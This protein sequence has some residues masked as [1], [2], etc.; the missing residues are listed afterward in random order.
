MDLLRFSG[1]NTGVRANTGST[2]VA[3]FEI[4]PGYAH[5]FKLYHNG[6]SH[7]TGPVIY[8]DDTSVQTELSALTVPVSGAPIPVGDVEPG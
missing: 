1:L 2:G 6:G 4:L 5:M 7:V 3:A 8:G